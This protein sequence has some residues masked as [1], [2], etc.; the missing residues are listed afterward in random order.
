MNILPYPCKINSPTAVALG[1]FDGVHPAHKAVISAAASNSL[2]LEGAVFTFS[3]NPNKSTSFVLSTQ[4]EKYELIKECGIKHLVSADFDSVRNLSAEEFVDKILCNCLNA[5][6]VFCGYNYRFGKGA[7]AD[8]NTLSTLCKDR[9]I[10]LTVI[11]EITLD[12]SV[13]SSTAIRKLLSQGEIKKASL[14][15]GRPYSI[16]GKIIHGNAIG[17]TIETPTLNIDVHKEK[18]LPRFGVYATLAHIEGKT[19]KAVTNIGLKP[20]V[21]SDS[22]TVEAYLLEVKGDFYNKDCKIELVD[23]LRPEEKFSNLSE[24]KSAISRDIEKAKHVLE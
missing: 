10:I 12:N 23:F 21:G 22:P 17:R 18:L 1:R 7:C 20:T 13:I 2:G 3:D 8:V 15:L 11:D 24:L 14:L 16:K 4:E 19:F 5:K 9:G 6:A